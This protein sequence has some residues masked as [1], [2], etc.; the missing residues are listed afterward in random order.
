MTL[1]RLFLAHTIIVAPAAKTRAIP[2][3]AVRLSL[4]VILLLAA[5][6]TPPAKAAPIVAGATV[7]QSR[8]ILDLALLPNTP[9]NPTGSPILLNG[10]FGVG[11]LTIFRET[12]V[13]DSILLSK[14][15]GRFFGSH[16]SLGDYVF[17]RVDPLTPANYSGVINNVVQDPVDPG[18]ATGQPSSFQ[19]GDISWGGAS[20]GF[21]FLTGPAAGITLFTDP[22]VPFSFSSTYD[23]LPPSLGTVNANSGPDFLNV[24]FNGQVVATMSGHR[25][26]VIPLPNVPDAGSTVMLLGVALS[27][28]A[29]FRRKLA[30]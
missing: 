19:S 15:D 13:G 26:D 7:I 28:F 21:E 2:V 16:P 29:L 24:L 12:Q 11:P 10:L 27:G 22:T 23:G 1:Y 30:A 25:V 14:V 8:A 18:F 9:F 5:V 17:G 4:G 6:A 3:T 20:F